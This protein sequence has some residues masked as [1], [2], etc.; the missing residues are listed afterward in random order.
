[1]S[2]SEKFTDQPGIE[3]GTFRLLDGCSTKFTLAYLVTYYSV[4]SIN[5][6]QL[7]CNV[8]CSIWASIVNHNDLIVMATIKVLKQNNVGIRRIFF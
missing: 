1:M 7:F 2:V 8:K 3:P 5:L 4:L 6:F